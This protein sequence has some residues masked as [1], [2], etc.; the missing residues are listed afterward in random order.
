MKFYIVVEVETKHDRG[1]AKPEHW[2]WDYSMKEV[3]N[4][5]PSLDNIATLKVVS[6]I[7]E[8][9]KVCRKDKN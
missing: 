7:G 3:L 1:L 4:K 8:D 2:S 6:T 5:V 9:G